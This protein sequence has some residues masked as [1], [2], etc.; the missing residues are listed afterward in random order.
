MNRRHLTLFLPLVGVGAALALCGC[1][2]PALFADRVQGSW[3]PEH[4]ELGGQELPLAAFQGAL[5]TLRGGQYDFV[6]DKGR[7]E[8]LLDG[9]HYAMDVVG[10]EG[11]NQGRTIAAIFKLEGDRLTVC[12]EL[13]SGPRPLQFDSPKGTRH[14]LISYRR[15]GQPD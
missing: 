5:L 11:P 8:V 2:T 14:F 9:D 4:A 15:V 13:G 6:T 1:M 3:A 7:Y 10:T 12:Y